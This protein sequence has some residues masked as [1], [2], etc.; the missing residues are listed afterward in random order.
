MFIPKKLEKFTNYNGYI[1]DMRL[2]C[3]HEVDIKHLCSLIGTLRK[4]FRSPY[5]R[6]MWMTQEGV[7][8]PLCVV[9]S[10]IGKNVRLTKL[11]PFS[12]A[13]KVIMGN[14]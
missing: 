13:E 7:D 14:N 9:Y 3:V 6:F 10:D 5:I 8:E 4:K 11:I 2:D 1:C 12:E